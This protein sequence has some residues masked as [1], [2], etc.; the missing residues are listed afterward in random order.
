MLIKNLVFFI[1]N[2]FLII[3]NRKLKLNTKDRFKIFLFA[4]LNIF[5]KPLQFLSRSLYYDIRRKFVGI[6]YNRIITEIKNKKFK[7]RDDIDLLTILADE[8]I[9]AYLEYGKYFF[10]IGAHIGKYA[11]LFADYYEKI[12]AFEPQPNNFKALCENIELNNL[13]NII[14]IQKAVSDKKG[15]IKLYISEFSVTHSIKEQHQGRYIDVEAISIDDFLKGRENEFYNVPL[16]FKIDVEG[17][18]DLVI[19]GMEN[20]LKN[21]K[22]IRLII[23]IWRNNLENKKFIEDFLKNLGY[24]LKQINEEYYLSYY[25]NSSS[26]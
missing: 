6:F 2:Q 10:D 26:K 7:V 15:K 22:N 14:P 24:I 11:I 13:K 20:L 12:Y 4:I 9:D 18:E 25:E 19:N 3:F 8:G 17:A 16:C 5:I 23:E 1:K 21:N